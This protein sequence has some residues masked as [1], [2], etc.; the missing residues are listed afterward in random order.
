MVLRDDYGDVV[1]DKAFTSERDA[2]EYIRG[3][4]VRPIGYAFEVE[5]VEPE[6]GRRGV[7]VTW[8]SARGLE[9]ML[10]S[11]AGPSPKFRA[12]VERARE[13][14]KQGEG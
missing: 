4:A 8:V 12:A 13:R 9:Q 5:L 2:Y 1:P 7:D 6:P 11:D 14:T 10:N 3:E